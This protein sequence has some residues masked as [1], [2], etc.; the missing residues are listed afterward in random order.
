MNKFIRWPGLIAFVVLMLLIGGVAYLFANSWVESYIEDT[1]S[2]MLGARVDVGSVRLSLQPMGIVINQ[3]DVTDPEKPMQNVVSIGSIRAQFDLLRAFMGQVIIKDASVNDMQFGTPRK[4]S[5]AIVKR[6]EPPPEPSFISKQLD[7]LGVDLPDGKQLM[8]REPL[9]VDERKDILEASVEEKETI[10][11]SIEDRLPTNDKMKD[12]EQR[13]KAITDGKIESLAD[14]KARQEA[15]E[16]LQKAIKADRDA[17]KDAKEHLQF[18]RKELTEQIKALRNA[19][20]EDRDRILGKYTFDESGLVNMSGL[21]FGGQIEGYLNKALY[22]YERLEPY[23]FVEDTDAKPKPVRDKGRFIRFPE[24]APKPDFLIENM[25]ASAI[26][27]AG[28]LSAKIAN[29]TNRQDV[30]NKPTTLDIMSEVLRDVKRLD[31]NAVFDYRKDKG[32]STADFTIDELLVKDFRISGGKDFPL[33]LQAANS[34]FKGQ[35]RLE[36]RKLTGVMHGDFTEA[37][38]LAER[39]SG[40]LKYISQAFKGINQFDLDVSVGGSLKKPDIS[41]RSDLDKS[42]KN[43]LEKQI[44]AE[45]AEFKAEIEQELNARL[46]DALEKIDIEGFAEDERA[47]DEK[48]ASL[49]DMLKAKLDDVKDQK[50][51]EIKDKVDA[52]KKKKEQEIKDKLKDALKR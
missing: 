35:I 3:L 9:L 48:I 1:G 41:I 21:L 49:D 30:I 43:S 5:G 36:D 40:M 6:P 26:L 33:S 44:K 23:I 8:E 45:I 2:D 22:W 50:E 19:P 28:K 14:L 17:L 13:F 37:E 52:E 31:V 7:A 20:K 10:W 38:F 27:P 47:V 16:A 51:Q 34:D 18:S 42:L 25:A 12:Y 4:T 15:L 46:G 32:F 39:Q 11:K 29:I 24:Y